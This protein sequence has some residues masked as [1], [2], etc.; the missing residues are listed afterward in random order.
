MDEFRIQH[1]LTPLNAWSYSF[2]CLLGWGAFVMPATVFLPQGGVWGS[3]L[4]FLIGGA[5]IAAVAMNYQYLANHCNGNGG[6]FYLLQ[7]NLNREH[8]FAASWAICF[9]H[10]LIIPLNSRAFTRMIRAILLE[11]AHIDWHIR[12]FQTNVDLL[13]FLIIAGVLILF[14]WMNSRGIRMV[15]QIQTVLAITLLLGITLLF[16]MALFS[17]VNIAEKMTPAV[18][19][20]KNFL[21]SFMVIFIMVPWAFVGFDSVPA[22]C[23]EAQFTKNK[24]G[25]I[26]VAAVITGSFAYMA[27][28][29][30]TLLGV[31]DLF[32]DWTD[33][34][35]QTGTMTG[36]NSI[37]VVYAARNLYGNT[38]L[39]I[40]LITLLSAILTGINGSI[41]MVSRLVFRMS[42]SNSLFPSLSKTNKNGVPYR[43]IG[44]CV[45]AALFLVLISGTFNTMEMVASICTAFGYGYCSAATL[46]RAVQMQSKK[47]IVTGLLGTLACLVWFILLMI[48]TGLTG[49]VLNEKV[50]VSLAAWVFLGIFG[51]A[52]TCRKPDTI[53]D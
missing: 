38:G 27:N 11:Y 51:Y 25:R 15:A 2:G 4:A 24:I 6:L 3:L 16:F 19:P 45:W 37:A 47:H 46:I 32:T 8:A 26:M 13:D 9:A 36:L 42:K 30:I 29:V 44:F 52:I 23:K 33:Y 34:T 21:S 10:L 40:A 14:A 12:L 49:Y 50:Y 53:L 39:V 35:R 41:A 48:P 17:G 22:L 18:Y 43:A 7:N 20:G 28:V 5:F 31:P 1:V